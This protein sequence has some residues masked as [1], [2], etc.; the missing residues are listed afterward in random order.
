VI[1][2]PESHHRRSIRLKGYDYACAG[3]YFVTI[4]AQKKVCLFGAIDNDKI[5]LNDAG[6]MIQT[7]WNDM[8]TFYAGIEIDAFI[9]MPN[10]IHGIIMI[11]A[12]SD[13]TSVAVGAG[14]RACPGHDGSPDLHY[15]GNIDYPN[16]SHRM[17][18]STDGQRAGTQRTIGKRIGEQRTDGQPQG[19][20]PTS[21]VEAGMRN[22]GVQTGLSLPDVVHRFKSMTTHQYIQGVKQSGWSPFPGRL[23][24]R[25]YWEHIVRHEQDLTR[26]REY[27]RHNPEKWALD[28][29]MSVH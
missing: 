27:I 26:L 13:I 22:G 23:W 5:V 24:Q 6:R 2:D 14:P 21:A 11:S 9:I 17:M 25:N 18:E 15:D 3:A 4:C 8:P 16:N 28:E 29:L 1:Y 20:A 12:P 7:V 19:V 10:H